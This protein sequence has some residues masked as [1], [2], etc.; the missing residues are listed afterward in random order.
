MQMVYEYG[1][2]KIVKKKFISNLLSYMD[3][4]K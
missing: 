3:F 2:W 4:D 1:V